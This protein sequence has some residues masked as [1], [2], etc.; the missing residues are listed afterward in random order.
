MLSYIIISTISIVLFLFVI[1]IYFGIKYVRKHN[2]LLINNDAQL[3]ND[4]YIS[5]V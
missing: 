1:I 3:N 2:Y 5:F 4:I